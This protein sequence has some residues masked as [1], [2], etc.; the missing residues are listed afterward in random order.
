M[1][2]KG[3]ADLGNNGDSYDFMLSNCPGQTLGVA[4]DAAETDFST[5]RSLN[6]G[7]LGYFNNTGRMLQTD[8][9]IAPI[10]KNRLRDHSGR[11]GHRI[12]GQVR[13]CLEDISP[14]ALPCFTAICLCS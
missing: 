11:W 6:P 7:W 4:K 1:Q 5:I 12:L 8:E 9:F 13:M 2:K 14:L 3:V 10:S